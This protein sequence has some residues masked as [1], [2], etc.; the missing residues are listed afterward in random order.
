MHTHFWFGVL[1]Q[2]LI[3]ATLAV[4]PVRAE[5]GDPTIETDHPQ[6]AGEG[7]FQEI[8]DCVRFATAGND[9]PQD[10]AIAMYLWMLN[11]QWHLASPQEWCVPG[12]VPD[13]AQSRDYESVVYDANRARF[14][15]GYGLC[16][17]VHAW[18]EPY[19]KALGMNARRRS[20][21][22]HSNSEIQYAGSWH[23]FDTDMA[24][25]LFRKDGTV[26]GYED[27]IRDPTLVDSVRTPLP[28][29]E[30]SGRSISGI[31]FRP[32]R[33]ATFVV[34]RLTMISSSSC[35]HLICSES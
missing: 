14:S 20:F 35:T 27:I 26:A 29:G 11:H 13:T 31:L 6:Y 21:P 3:L 22:G 16:G 4:V 23:A 5:V 28:H 9:S 34:S 7:A 10:R 25:L 15:Y 19:W 18:N 12:R 2:V 24:G 1:L 30:V 32:A 33:L 17:T 8:E